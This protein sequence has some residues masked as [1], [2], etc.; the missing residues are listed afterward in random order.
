MNES[1]TSGTMTGTERE[2]G[3]EEPDE[4]KSDDDYPTI[5]PILSPGQN[6]K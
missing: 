4:E 1:L 3:E 2:T 6:L 5:I